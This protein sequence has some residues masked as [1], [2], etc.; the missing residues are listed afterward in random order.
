MPS[1]PTLGD[2]MK[3]TFSAL[4]GDSDSVTG[5]VTCPKLAPGLAGRSEHSSSRWTSSTTA[6]PTTTTS[7]GRTT[8]KANTGPGRRGTPVTRHPA[9]ST[10]KHECSHQGMAPSEGAHDRHQGPGMVTHGRHHHGPSTSTSTAKKDKLIEIDETD[11]PLSA[12]AAADLRFTKLMT[13]R[14]DRR[15]ACA[16]ERPHRGIAPSEGAH[17]R[18]HHGLS[19]CPSTSCDVPGGMGLPAEEAHP[20]KRREFLAPD[21][22]GP[23]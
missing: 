1:T 2:F 17:G 4:S 7:S 22:L 3:N 5:A 16:H 15:M 8:M 12:Q 14:D 13:E 20:P 19:T 18:H 11:R 9:P 10:A 6:S 23:A 21:A